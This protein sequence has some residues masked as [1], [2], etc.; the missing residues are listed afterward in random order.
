M[1]NMITTYSSLESGP[2]QMLETAPGVARSSAAMPP[3]AQP[4]PLSLKPEAASLPDLVRD[5]RPGHRSEAVVWMVL[6]CSALA[7]LTLSLW[8]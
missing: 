4:R 8:L 6:A 1:N 3:K 2:R 5:L 7:L